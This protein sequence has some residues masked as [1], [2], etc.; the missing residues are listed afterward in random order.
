MEVIFK[1]KKAVFLLFIVLLLPLCGVLYF[2]SEQ[3]AAWLLR[4]FIS[5]SL[6]AV[7]GVGLCSSIPRRALRLLAGLAYFQLLGFFLAAL[8]L[9]FYFQGE[10]FNERFFFH[11][12]LNSLAGAV[13]SFPALLFGA[14]TFFVVL[15]LL[16]VKALLHAGEQQ[17]KSAFP[18]FALLLLA[19]LA[20]EPDMNILVGNVVASGNIEA[21]G[22]DYDE[23]LSLGLHLEALESRVENTRPGK[24]LLLIYLESLEKVYT[25][26][27][28]FPGLT[29][30]LNELKSQ[31]LWFSQMLQTRGTSWTVA[32]MM[33][34]QCGT[35][36]LTPFGPTGN[37]LLRTGI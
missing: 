11:A 6:F 27:S 14:V 23:A 15:A 30:Y 25:E 1:Y 20:L 24:N 26:E 31:A 18:I 32:G 5:V 28:I 22:L 36:L 35:P 17:P 16:T 37:D 34:T 4:T 7:A 19:S 2:N 29:P 13:D 21:G 33:A 12:T 9:S 3:S 8:L 10:S